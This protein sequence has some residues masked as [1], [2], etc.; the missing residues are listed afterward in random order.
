MSLSASLGERIPLFGDGNEK[1]FATAAPD[2]EA[3]GAAELDA[4]AEGSAE[5]EPD[6]AGSAVASAEA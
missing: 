1:P 5:A 4:T 6:G 3:D 2:A